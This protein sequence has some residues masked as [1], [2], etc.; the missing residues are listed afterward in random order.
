MMWRWF[1]I[2]LI[3]LFNSDWILAQVYSEKKTQH[4]FA[5]TYFGLNSQL[6]PTSGQLFFQSQYF[7]FP[8]R[9]LHRVTLGGMHFWG[10][11]DF[12]MNFPLTNSGKTNLAKD[13]EMKFTSGA[14]LSARYYPWQLKNVKLRPFLGVSINTMQLSLGNQTLGNRVEGFITTSVLSGLSYSFKNWRVNAE[15][16]YLPQNSRDFY[17]DRQ[18]KN[19]FQLPRS[20]FSLGLVRHFDFTLTEEKPKLSGRTKAIEENIL[21]EK[22][23]NSISMGFAPSGSYSLKS[24]SFSN[25][26]QSLPRHKGSFNLE[27]NIGYLINKLKLHVGLTYRSYRS[28]SSSYRLNHVMRRQAFSLEGFKFLANYHGFVPFVGLSLSSE[29]W[30]VALF[31]GNNQK[32]KTIRTSFFS[33]GIIFGWD[34]QTSPI[35]I[36]VL[37]TNLRYY[38]YQKISDINGKISRVDQFEFNFIQFVFYPNRWWKIRQVKEQLVSS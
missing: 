11:L 15:W 35:D 27:Y 8:L 7:D 12:N 9:T 18:E 31:E 37:R 2:F 29:R 14:D 3:F 16:M 20:Y 4:R 36:W 6:I 38:P 28:N 33:P 26:L 13:V 32:G 25:E 21:E 19:S 24:P 22:N 34:I 5:Q 17:S 10:K 1:F 30:G 23:L